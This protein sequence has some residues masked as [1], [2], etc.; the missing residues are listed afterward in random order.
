MQAREMSNNNQTEEKKL[1]K[2]WW[3]GQWLRIVYSIWLDQLWYWQNVRPQLYGLSGW[4]LFVQ[5]ML[6]TLLLQLTLAL[7]LGIFIGTILYI[8]WRLLGILTSIS[9]LLGSLAGIINRANGLV[10]GVVF[11]NLL[12]TLAVFQQSTSH[13]EV[14]QLVEQVD[15]V[16][17]GIIVGGLSGGLG[18]GL[19]IGIQTGSK[20]IS[21]GLGTFLLAI[22][23][24]ITFVNDLVTGITFAI[25]LTLGIYL[26]GLWSTRQVRDAETRRRLA[27]PEKD[28]S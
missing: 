22:M 1:A 14:A 23:L 24:A 4:K 13:S 3:P 27:N 10:L 20:E 28:I 2:W 21:K 8:D 18:I 16:W 26:G 25:F 12:T 17:G 5:A 19:V 7:V 15:P 6:G 9:V 11:T